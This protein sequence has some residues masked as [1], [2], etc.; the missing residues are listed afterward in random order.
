M[1]EKLKY[2]LFSLPD[3]NFYKSYYQNSD[4]IKIYYYN[5]IIDGTDDGISVFYDPEEY[6]VDKEIK[7]LNKENTLKTFNDVSAAMDYVRYLVL[8]IADERHRLYHYFM[9]KLKY[10][11]ISYNHESFGYSGIGLKEDKMIRCDIS[12]LLVKGRKVK[13][14]FV[15]VFKK[16]FICTLS[17]YPENPGWSEEKVCPETDVDKIFEY[18]LNLKVDNC[19]DIPLAYS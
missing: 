5:V 19:D 7:Y 13:Y 12:D 17:F 4:G 11:E 10:F 9:F 1:I 15:V 8:V 18:I 16:G 2:A 3:Y 6:F 14:N